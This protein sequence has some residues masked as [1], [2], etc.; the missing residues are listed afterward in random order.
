MFCLSNGLKAAVADTNPL[1]LQMPGARAVYPA[2]LQSCDQFRTECRWQRDR[3]IGPWLRGMWFR[4]I[5]NF[6]GRVN[7]RRH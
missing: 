6:G 4:T 3:A 7:S 2:R 1:R 5:V